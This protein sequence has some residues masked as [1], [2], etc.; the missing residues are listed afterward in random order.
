MIT[1]KVDIPCTYLVRIYLEN[2]FG[3]PVR[4]KEGIH[5]SIFLCHVEKQACINQKVRSRRWSDQVTVELTESLYLRHGVFLTD[6]GISDINSDYTDLIYELLFQ[7]MAWSEDMFFAPGSKLNYR[8]SI[9]KFCDK[10]GFPEECL[11]Y[12]RAKKA[13]QRK[14]EQDKIL[15]VSA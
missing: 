5:K 7:T 12:E 3:K 8:E 11:S 9:E 4:F 1:F 10:M 6:K 15:K 14:R 13:W 2:L